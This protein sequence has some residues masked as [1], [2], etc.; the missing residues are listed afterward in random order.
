M[1]HPSLTLVQLAK[2]LGPSPCLAKFLCAKCFAR[3]RTVSA[4]IGFIL[5]ACSATCVSLGAEARSFK[6]QQVKAGFIYN[7]AKFVEWPADRLMESN[8]PIVI[9][10]MA[11]PTFCEEL[12]KVVKGRKINEHVIVVRELKGL[13][14]NELPHILF[15]AAAESEIIG[16]A[17]AA[18][19]LPGV[20]TVG[21][22][23][24]FASNGG[25]INFMM[26]EGKVRFE[27]NIRAATEARLKVSAQLQ[28]L[29][30]AIRK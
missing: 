21:E 14:K 17:I 30:K 27:I 26:E 6:E 19:Q 15:V 12:Q 18:P 10:V 11:S 4:L 23:D 7:F 22:S 20:L 28:K 3:A 8:S 13:D 16:K 5:F 9:G 29:A 2:A 24:A 25:I 1:R